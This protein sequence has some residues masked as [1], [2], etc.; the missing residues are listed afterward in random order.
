[1]HAS[2]SASVSLSLPHMPTRIEELES[3][4]RGT[5]HLISPGRRVMECLTLQSSS[6]STLD[7][8]NRQC[9]VIQR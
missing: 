4:K 1:M 5:Q 9:F 7:L 8:S 6:A 3:P 2:C